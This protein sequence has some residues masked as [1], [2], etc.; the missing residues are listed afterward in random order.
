MHEQESP[1]KRRLVLT[2]SIITGLYFVTYLPACWIAMRMDAHSPNTQIIS[3]VYAP[4]SILIIFAPQPVKSVV[5]RVLACGAPKGCE[6][7]TD[8][9]RGIGW[10]T[11]NDSYTHL[12]M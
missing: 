1:R 9:N 5:F 3:N 10:S 11:E 12:S 2:L 8:W 7:M 4:I 6:V